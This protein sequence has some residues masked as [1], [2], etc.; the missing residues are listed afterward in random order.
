MEEVWILTC[1]YKLSYWFLNLAYILPPL[2]FGDGLFLHILRIYWFCLSIITQEG[3]KVMAFPVGT[4]NSYAFLTYHTT[5]AIGQCFKKRR[6][7]LTVTSKIS[8]LLFNELV[9]D[10]KPSLT[11]WVS[12]WQAQHQTECR[13]HCC[14]GWGLLWLLT[15]HSYLEELGVTSWWWGH[16]PFRE[17]QKKS[18]PQKLQLLSQTQLSKSPF[19]MSF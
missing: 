11:W 5:A 9:K 2:G 6:N 19:N 7:E 4:G 16:F 3:N 12:L 17:H 15:L 10:S 1:W 18:L 14:P 8:S 13:R